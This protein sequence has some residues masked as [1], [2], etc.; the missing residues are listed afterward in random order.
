VAVWRLMH[1]LDP[2]QL[3]GRVIL[4]PRLNQPACVTGTSES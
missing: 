1:E 3:S 4:M 2:A